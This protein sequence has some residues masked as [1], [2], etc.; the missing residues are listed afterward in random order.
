V[1]KTGQAGAKPANTSC[2]QCVQIL[3]AIGFKKPAQIIFPPDPCFFVV[4]ANPH[5]FAQKAPLP[6][7]DHDEYVHQH[8]AVDFYR[9]IRSVFRFAFGVFYRGTVRVFKW[10]Q[11][12]KQVFYVMPCVVKRYFSLSIQRQIS[13]LSGAGPT[14]LISPLITL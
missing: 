13:G 8:E 4:A 11:P 5:A 14:K 10:A 12:I 7:F 2:E 1:R 6:L 3:A 9:V